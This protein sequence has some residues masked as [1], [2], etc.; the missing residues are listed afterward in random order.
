L[1]YR[2]RNQNHKDAVGV[3]KQIAHPT[4]VKAAAALGRLIDLK[5]AS[6]YGFAGVS[7]QQRKQAHAQSASRSGRR[8]RAA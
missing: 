8:A 4:A 2:S 7:T 5:D 6:H 1:K 3:V